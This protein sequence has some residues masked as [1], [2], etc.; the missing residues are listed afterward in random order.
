[1]C[2]RKQPACAESVVV[3]GEP[4]V[5]AKPENA[6]RG[7]WLSGVCA[8]PGLV[9]QLGCLSVGVIVEHLTDQLECGGTGL[10]GL[11]D[12]GIWDMISA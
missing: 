2:E 9:E 8:S 6:Q 3:A 4:V 12:R 5:L 7:E 1:M 10:A 11:P